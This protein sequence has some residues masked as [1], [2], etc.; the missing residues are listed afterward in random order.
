MPMGG[1]AGDSNTYMV[2]VKAQSGQN[3]AT[4]EVEVMVTNVDEKGMVTLSSM[5]PVVDMEITATLSDPDG[6]VSG[7]MWQWSKT[8]DMSDMGSW[9]DI[10]GATMMSYPPVEADDTYYLQATASYTDGEGADKT[11]MK[12]TDNMVTANDP[13][14]FAADTDTRS[15]PENTAAGMN[16]GEPVMATDPDEGDTLTYA[17]SGDDAASFDIDTATGQ[18]MAKAA[19]DYETKTEYM[20]TVTA[21]DGDSAS[22][23]IMVTIMVTGVNEAPEFATETDD[24]SVEENTAAGMNIGEPVMATDP[25]EGDT[26]TYALSGDDAASFDIDTSTGQLMA[27]AALD[28]ETKT[29]YMVTVTATDGDSAS[30]SI[31]VTIMVT[32][33]ELAAEYDANGNGMVDKAEVITAINDYLFEETLSKAEVIDLINLYLFGG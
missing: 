2:T 20:V 14:M 18:L 31:M 6:M 26:L 28:Y 19:L 10:D 33:I 27:K 11:A 12:T 21:T 25:D 17:L 7:E 1:S 16:I 29:E 30:D 8:M 4:H 9:M 3:M 24:R 15:V 32:D 23:S 5:T 22:D 13:P